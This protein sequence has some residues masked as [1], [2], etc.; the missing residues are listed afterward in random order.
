MKNKKLK[1]GILLFGISLLLWNCEKEIDG[2]LNNE[3]FGITAKFKKGKIMF[4]IL[5]LLKTYI[6]TS[7]LWF[8]FMLSIIIQRLINH[9]NVNDVFGVSLLDITLF[10]FAI[11]TALFVLFALNFCS[12]YLEDN[13]ITFA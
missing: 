12:T 11:L 13:K 1:I 10:V 3:K 6:V 7:I 5:T 2:D 8:I 4:K 9:E